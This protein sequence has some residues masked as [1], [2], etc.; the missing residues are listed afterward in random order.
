MAPPRRGAAAPDRGCGR[1]APPRR[2]ASREAAATLP[3]SRG[4]AARG[5]RIEAVKAG[6]GRPR[7]GGGLDG[8]E[9]RRRGDRSLKVARRA[10]PA[11]WG[12]ATRERGREE[13]RTS[14]PF[15]TTWA[16]IKRAEFE[17]KKVY[18]V[19]LADLGMAR[20]ILRHNRSSAPASSAFH[21]ERG[22]GYYRTDSWLVENKFCLE[23]R[24][25][26]AA[27]ASA[28]GNIARVEEVSPSTMARAS[29]VATK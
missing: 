2:L 12:G 14:V 27:L 16:G 26:P 10:A 11:R 7:Q 13:S 24:I 29:Y 5:R 28:S 20:A 6:T 9:R 25:V 19:G 22:D 8:K 21:A 17:K 15:A 1:A 23:R 18:Q 3:A 4:A